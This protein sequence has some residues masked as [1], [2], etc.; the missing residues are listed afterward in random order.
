[1]KYVKNGHRNFIVI[2]LIFFS[3]VLAQAAEPNVAEVIKYRRNIMKSQREHMAVASAIVQGNVEFKDQLVDHVRALEATTRIISKLFPKDS[4][5]G[6]TAALPGVWT[7]NAE[8][9]ARAMDTRDKSAALSKVVSAGESQNYEIRL[10]ELL[11]S[12]KA[13]HKIFRKKDEK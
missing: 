2:G 10:S 8:F 6:D 11:D 4:D 5:V 13:C 9:E 1:M 3:S 7:N 12:C